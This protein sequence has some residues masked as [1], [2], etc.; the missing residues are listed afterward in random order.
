MSQFEPLLPLFSRRWIVPTLRQLWVDRGAKFVTL[1][2]A[3]NSSPGAM[4]ATVKDLLKL[5]LIQRNPGYGHPM[6]PEYV[7]TVRGARLAERCDE[8]MKELSAA[9]IKDGYT[10][11]WSVMVLSC[12]S[13]GGMRFSELRT[14]LGVVTDRSLTICLKSLCKSGAVTRTVTDGFPPSVSYALSPNA[15]GLGDSIK[16][17]I[18]ASR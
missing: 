1:M 11:K 18:E 17:L 7:L 12:L 3:L 14:S 6:R 2:K 13:H 10:S 9:G 5:G 15:K 16:R 8:L 4:R